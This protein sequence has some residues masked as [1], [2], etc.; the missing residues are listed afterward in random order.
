MLTFASARGGMEVL[1]PGPVYPPTKPCTSNVGSAHRRFMTSRRS[2][3]RNF[4]NWCA[5]AKGFT[6]KP[7][8]DRKST[9]LNSSHSQISYAVF[10]LKKKKKKAKK[11]M[12]HTYKHAETRLKQ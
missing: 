5:A 8:L 9:R 3:T 1:T 6:W 12:T 7:D 4:V 10:C 2:R 11:N